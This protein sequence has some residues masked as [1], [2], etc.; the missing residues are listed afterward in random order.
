MQTREVQWGELKAV[1]KFEHARE[2]P[3][4]YRAFLRRKEAALPDVG[5]EAHVS[6]IPP[7]M[8]QPAGIELV[9]GR[10]RRKRV[11]RIEEM[12]PEEERMLRVSPQPRNWG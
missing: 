9:P 1:R 7:L 11:V 12:R 3:E 2:L 8:L 10:R 4:D 6:V 5:H